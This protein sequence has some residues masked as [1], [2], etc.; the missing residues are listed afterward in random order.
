MKC[1]VVACLLSLAAATEINFRNSGWLTDAD[2]EAVL[3]DE[4]ADTEHHVEVFERDLRNLFTSLPKNKHGNLGHATVRYALHRYFVGAYGWYI[5]GLE[6]RSSSNNSALPNIIENEFEKHVGERGVDL[7]GLATLAS[8]LD[9]LAEKEIH[10]RLKDMYKAHLLS[11]DSLLEKKQANEVLQ[12]YLVSFLVG[13]NWTARSKAD[14]DFKV[15]VFGKT[16]RFFDATMAWYEPIREEYI[17]LTNDFEALAR[18]ATDVSERYHDLNDVSCENMKA[19]LKNKESKKPG[20]IRLS[21]FYNLSLSGAWDFF[22][23]VELLRALGTLDETDPKQPSVIITNYA[24]SQINCVNA[25]NLYSICCR[26]VCDDLMTELEKEIGAPMARADDIL[27][28]VSKLPSDSVVAPRLLPAALRGH[29]KEVEATHDG[30]VPLHGRLFAQWMHH[31]YPLDCP[32]PHEAGIVSASTPAEWLAQTGQSNHRVSEEEMR[33]HIEAD[34]CGLDSEGKPDC[35]E[36]STELSW[37]M[38]EELLASPAKE[39]AEVISGCPHLS[40]LCFLGALLLGRPL[41]SQ[42]LGV[43]QR[44]ETLMSVALALIAAAYFAD[45]LDGSIFLFAF[46]GHI[47]TTGAQFAFKRFAGEGGVLPFGQGKKV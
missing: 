34:H 19:A 31:A 23:K 14:L 38:T 2:A 11:V 36:E 46:F 32:Y 16:Y 6:P 5:E 27:A 42:K 4:I 8:A 20:R 24:N 26:N 37:S 21:Q 18:V 44:R 12:T 29:L 47:A 30:L 41:V 17:H 3:Q 22:E 43:G 33:Q 28:L 13:N 9:E 40:A 1:S 15:K 10:S 35:G 45:L 25:T 7:H 39:E